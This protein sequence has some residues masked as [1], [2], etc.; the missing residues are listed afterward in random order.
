MLLDV[1]A[2]STGYPVL[3]IPQTAIAGAGH[4][5]RQ[6]ERRRRQAGSTAKLNLPSCSM[7]VRRQA[8]RRLRNSSA[9]IQGGRGYGGGPAGIGSHPGL[10][11]PPRVTR[12]FWVPST[13]NYNLKFFLFYIFHNYY[14]LFFPIT[15]K[16]PRHGVF[17]ARPIS[18]MAWGLKIQPRLE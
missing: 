11:S 8:G 13:T 15:L 3:R 12:A 6:V 1:V 7:P 9:R 4:R 2:I 14:Q 5:Q 16:F 18:N 10:K 17:T